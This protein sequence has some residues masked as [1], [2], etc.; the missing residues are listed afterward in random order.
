MRVHLATHFFS[1]KNIDMF[2]TIAAQADGHEW[3]AL[4]QFA[5]A[6]HF[7]YVKFMLTPY[8]VW[9]LADDC[10]VYLIEGYQFF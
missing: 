5:R 1:D 7:I 3:L 4:F 6:T 2:S 9:D 10:I 8:V